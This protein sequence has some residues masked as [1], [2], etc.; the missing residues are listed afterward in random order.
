MRDFKAQKRE[1]VSL[2]KEKEL[3][4]TM[5][6]NHYDLQRLREKSKEQRALKARPKITK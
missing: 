3:K 6:N 1:Y 5:R 2:N 4:K